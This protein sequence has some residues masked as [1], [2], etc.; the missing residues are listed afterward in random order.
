MD[1]GRSCDARARAFF[2]CACVRARIP[3]HRRKNVVDPSRIFGP[4]GERDGWIEKEPSDKSRQENGGGN[5][6][7]FIPRVDRE[8]QRREIYNCVGRELIAKL[9]GLAM[10]VRELPLLCP[11]I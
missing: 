8:R 9:I 7:G 4:D 11:A 5:N 1:N 6:I 2:V 3:V 10:R